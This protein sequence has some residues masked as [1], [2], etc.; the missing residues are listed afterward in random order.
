VSRTLTAEVA[1]WADH[2]PSRIV[3]RHPSPRNNR[4]LAK[5]RWFETD[6]VP[7]IRDRVEEVVD[8]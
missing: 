2:L 6:V 1:R 4:W 7:A 3:M 5:N 8:E